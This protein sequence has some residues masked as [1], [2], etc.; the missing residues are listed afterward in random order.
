MVKI[1][2]GKK[3]D[4]VAIVDHDDFER[5]KGF[6]WSFD[7]RYACRHLYENDKYKKIYM[8]REILDAKEIDHANRNKLD[9]RRCNLRKTNHSLNGANKTTKPGKYLKGVSFAAHGKKKKRWAASVMVQNKNISLGIYLCPI[10]AH[11]AYRIGARKY[12]GEFASCLR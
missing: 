6:F 7:G 10:E 4:R 5:L 1:P 12:F 2:L 8:H 9:N 3:Q 11:L